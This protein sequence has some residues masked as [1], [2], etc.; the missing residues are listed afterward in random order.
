M[1]ELFARLR[2]RKIVQ[3]ALAYAAAAFALLQGVDIVA[4]QFGWPEGLQR[5]ITLAMV[6]GFFVVLVLAWYHGERGAQKVSGTELLILALVLAV[7]GGILWKFAPAPVAAAP[8]PP[9]APAPRHDNS[10]AVLPFVDMSQAGDQ[11][12]FS[13]GLSE[14]LLNLLAQV[15]ELRVI[16]RTSS[17]SFKGKDVDAATIARTLGVEH[18]L[19]G[20]VRKSGN[21]LRITAQLIRASDSSHLW[22]QTYDRELTDIFKVQDE[23]ANAVVE[24]LKLKLLPNQQLSNPYQ[25][26][27]TEAYN[28]YLRGKALL[29]RQKAENLAMAKQA[30][31]RAIALDPTYAAP[32]AALADVEYVL[33][34]FA[35]DLA[36]KQKALAVAERAVALGPN[37]ADAHAARGVTRLSFFRDWDGARADFDQ[38][39]RLNASSGA[40]QLGKYRL[41]MAF[42][43]TDDAVATGRKAVLVDPL[44]T[45][46]WISL[47]RA[48]YAQGK[49]DEARSVLQR[50]M[51]LSP[52]SPYGAYALGVNHLARGQA[53]AALAVFRRSDS[54]YR[55]TG[56]AMA[57]HSLGHARESRQALEQAIRENGVDGAYQIAQ[58]YAWRGEDDK[59]FEWLQL[60]MDRNDGG[61]TFIKSDPIIGRLAAD[62]RYAALIR[63]MGLP[64]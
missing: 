51:E 49:L 2:Q 36:S 18:L 3:W 63:K 24:S 60:A 9:T 7:G 54:V 34:D 32:Q 23:I 4:Q 39:L 26:A 47:G 52:D 19:E 10:I 56:I 57:E 31:E 45:L 12:Y 48:L 5:G 17:F 13:D 28:E 27:N 58:A 55:P 15:P 6:L 30:F 59:A 43:R 16:A 21:T 41:L 37:L 20:S 8:A 38:A 46:A 50:A 11:A 35:G 14:E 61:L 62:A 40:A 1:T 42:G 33:A 25:S 22:S 44:S 64:Q 29:N 53:E